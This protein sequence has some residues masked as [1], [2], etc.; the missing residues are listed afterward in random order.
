MNTL[1][2]AA[3][4][5]YNQG[6]GLGSAAKM[7]GNKLEFLNA[8]AGIQFD[9]NNN[10]ITCLGGSGQIGILNGASGIQLI[11]NIIYNRVVLTSSTTPAVDVS[12]G[13]YFFL[14]ITSNIAVVIQNPTNP[15][16]AGFEQ[17]IVFE[18]KN[19]SGG[20]LTTQPTFSA[21]AGGYKVTGSLPAI[22]NGQRYRI[23]FEY[24]QDAGLWIQTS[25]TPFVY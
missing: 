8:G 7:N 12:Q 15:P 5:V 19:S 3:N 17:R 22:T 23:V 25:I 6:S 2:T 13:T 11:G 16:Q 24:S 4:T 20:A 21:T 14:S 1:A 18:I 10:L 9:G